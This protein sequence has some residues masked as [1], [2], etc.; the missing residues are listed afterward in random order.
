MA[1]QGDIEEQNFEE[2]SVPINRLHFYPQNPRR[3]PMADEDAIRAA[4]CADEGVIN[5]AKH[6]SANGLNPLDRIAVIAHPKLPQHFVVVEG[7]RRLC[8]LQLLRDPERAPSASAKKIFAKLQ[9]DGTPVSTTIAAVYFGKAET[10][11]TWMSVKHEGEQGGIGTV[12]WDATQK[13]R[14]NRQGTTSQVRPKNPNM[15]SL[16]LLDYAEAKGLLNTEERGKIAITT[17]TRYLSNPNVRAALALL[18]A[19]DLT[20]D[21]DP[22]QFDAAMRRFLLDAIPT[23]DPNV[24]PPVSSRTTSSERKAYAEKLRQDGIAPTE[25]GAPPYEPTPKV[26]ETPE[27]NKTTV[28]K[29]RGKR[30]PDLRP[31]VVRTDFRDVSGDPALSRMVIEGKK[32]RADDFVFSA[33]YIVRAILERVVN[34]YAKRNGIG[35]SRDLEKLITACA[36][37]AESRTQPAPRAIVQVMNKTASNQHASHA[38]DT[39]GAGVHGGII[40]S[41]KDIRRNWDTLQPV[42]EWLSTN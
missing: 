23:G 17:I 33:N 18:T 35:V 37:H 31:Y 1:K 19:E 27:P 22:Q 5:L 4:L 34:L 40:P 36:R 6:L 29:K 39:L 2:I 28:A 13:T 7:N 11:R 41:A 8:A 16:A 14:F 30:S 25:R 15:Q 42:F 20:T 3:E 9:N 21:A 10:A 12:E 32:L 24:I 38:P 26:E